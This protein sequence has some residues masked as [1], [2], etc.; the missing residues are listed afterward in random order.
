VATTLDCEVLRDLYGSEEVRRAFDSRALVQAWLDV[1]V[2]LAEAQ[3]ELGIIPTA[4]ARTIAKEADA[5]QFD[6]SALRAGVA[7]SQHPLVPLIRALV[8]RCGQDGDYV[9]W[10]ATTQDIMDTGL[11]LQ[12]RA[13][14]EPIRRDLQRVVRAA[15]GLA[16]RFAGA[17]MAG[18]THG[19][20][21]VPITFGLKAASWTNELLRCRTRLSVAEQDVLAAQLGGAA[22]TMASIGADAT[23]LR[24][25]FCRRLGLADTALSWHADRNRLRDLGHALTEIAAAGDRIAS[26]II[27][28]QSTEIAEVSAPHSEHHVGSSTMPQKQ[29]PMLCEYVVASARL[30]RGAT[31][32]LVHSPA[33]A[34]ERDMGAWAAEWI[35]IPQALILTGGLLA[36]LADTLEGLEVNTEKMVENL[37][38]SRGQI[39]AEAVMMELAR[40][41]GHEEAH[42]LISRISRRAS[43]ERRSFSETLRGDPT[44]ADAF[45]PARLVEVLDPLSYLGVSETSANTAAGRSDATLYERRSR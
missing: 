28:L 41:V 20:H 42:R 29:N 43:A 16:R 14:L 3:A 35:A 40:T 4:A 18:R 8:Q 45:A 11:A 17:P 37:A 1:E 31:S 6:L 30:V 19:Q 26:E 36:K 25:V 10:G 21:A 34:H 13:A 12:I 15:G 22:G 33:H 7:E 24:A 44:V 27:R 32:V 23:A 39:M 38:I 9:H 5:A 2:A